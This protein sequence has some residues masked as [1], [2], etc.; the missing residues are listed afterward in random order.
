M[1]SLVVRIENLRAAVL[2][3]L[4]KAIALQYSCAGRDEEWKLTSESASTVQKKND[5]VHADAKFVFVG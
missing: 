5:A 1:V 4:Q 3:F 2:F